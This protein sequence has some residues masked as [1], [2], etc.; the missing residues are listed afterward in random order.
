MTAK[1]KNLKLFSAGSSAAT[2]SLN[3][4]R[5]ILLDILLTPRIPHKKQQV[6]DDLTEPKPIMA[7]ICLDAGNLARSAQ[8]V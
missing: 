5:T 4:Y 3:L 7:K 2:Y 8:G 6:S 1:S